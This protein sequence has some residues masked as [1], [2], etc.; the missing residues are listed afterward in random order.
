MSNVKC[1][2]SKSGF[3]LLDTMIYAALFAV[4]IGSVLVVVYQII[5]GRFRL[6]ARV[7]LVEETNFLMRKIEWALAG[8]DVVNQPAANATGTTLSVN[9]LGYGSNP[10]VITSTSSVAT[11]AYGGGPAASLTNESLLVR[12]LVFEH[13]G[14]TN[15]GVKVTFTADFRPRFQYTIYNASATIETTIYAR[16]Q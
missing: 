14:G 1:Q 6:L 7:E 3:T 13:L 12:N 10:I 15:P 5:E 11:I 4:T 9:K 16:K 8:L 2:T